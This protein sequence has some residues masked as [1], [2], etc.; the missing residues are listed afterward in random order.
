MLKE[1]A[2]R[3]SPGTQGY[4]GPGIEVRGKIQDMSDARRVDYELGIVEEAEFF[5]SGR[6]RVFGI[7][8][9][10]TQGETRVGV[11]MCDPIL[12]QFRA[13]YRSGVLTAREMASRGV[14]VQRFH[15]R[16]MGNSDGD[17][18]GLGL[19]SMTEDAR[20]AGALIGGLFDGLSV[21][22]LGVNL[23]SYP[24]AAASGDGA[25]LILDSP[26]PNGTQY[27]RNALR[28]HSV[29][30]LRKD[31]SEGLTMTTLAEE[32]KRPGS[33]VALLGCRLSSELY[34]SIA[35][36]TII[37]QVEAGTRRPILLFGLG[38]EGSLRPEG[39]KTLAQLSDLGFEVDVDVRAKVDPFWYVENAAPEDQ[40]ETKE[41]AERIAAWLRHAST[42][43]AEDVVPNG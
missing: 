15:Y 22:Y 3:R 17:V 43:V 6:D 27:F 42:G 19:A 12:A 36:T 2:S 24:A 34:E 11:V 29:Y 1:V 26:P 39:A 21:A 14:V 31:T 5:G 23:G 38:E 9:R 8:Y 37:E 41:T 18:T 30:K 20:E 25:P 35:G 4:P 13:H 10:P 28:A 33:D 16:G 32:L 7:R 40:P